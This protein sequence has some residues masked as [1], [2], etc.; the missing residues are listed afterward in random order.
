MGYSNCSKLCKTRAFDLHLK[1]EEKKVPCSESQSCS[2]LTSPSGGTKDFPDRTSRPFSIPLVK[3]L[4]KSSWKKIP[5]PKPDQ[6]IKTVLKSCLK[7]E[8]FLLR[9][10][11]IFTE[12]LT[13]CILQ[14][15]LRINVNLAHSYGIYT[16]RKNRCFSW[17]L[18][19][20]AVLYCFLHCDF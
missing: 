1:T 20:L 14:T 4:K 17:C 8:A 7:S 16:L 12:V 13:E 10:S 11:L 18:H 19:T 2:D 3:S 6:N 9:F 15:I 5:Q